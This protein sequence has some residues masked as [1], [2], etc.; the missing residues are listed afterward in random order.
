MVM[1]FSLLQ[2]KV[3]HRVIKTF[4]SFGG[5][6]RN[7]DR[8]LSTKECG[9][10]GPHQSPKFLPTASQPPSR[11]AVE[12]QTAPHLAPTCSAPCFA[13]KVMKDG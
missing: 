11:P 7:S 8:A 3:C 1:P 10:S 6:K 13:M 9:R 12:K 2:M 4:T 5:C